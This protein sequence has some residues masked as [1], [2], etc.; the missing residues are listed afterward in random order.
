MSIADRPK[1]ADLHGSPLVDGSTTNPVNPVSG[2]NEVLLVTGA[3]FYRLKLSKQIALQGL[4]HQ[5]SLVR[6]RKPSLYPWASRLC[7][8]PMRIAHGSRSDRRQGQGR[9]R[10][11]KNA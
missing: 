10:I 1:S 6:A 2:H 8:T 7:L 5:V 9:R 3:H 11:F 4:C